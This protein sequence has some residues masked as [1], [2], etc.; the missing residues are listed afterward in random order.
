MNKSYEL[1]DGY[2]SYVCEYGHV[3]DFSKIDLNSLEADAKKGK[4]YKNAKELISDIKG[5]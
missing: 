5:G 3:H 2:G 1:N 4:S